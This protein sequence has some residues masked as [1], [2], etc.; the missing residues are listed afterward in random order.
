MEVVSTPDE[1]YSQPLSI[2]IPSPPD[3]STSHRQHVSPASNPLTVRNPTSADDDSSHELNDTHDT[4]LFSTSHSPSLSVLPPQII[5]IPKSLF[6]QA[7]KGIELSN[8]NEEVANN[9]FDLLQLAM[10]GMD[11]TPDNIVQIVGMG[12][13]V[14]EGLKRDNTPLS[15]NDKKSIVMIIV[16]RLVMT[17]DLSDT[18]KS[19]LNDIFVPLLL[20]GIIDSLC[21]LDVNDIASPA[22]KKT[23]FCCLSA[24]NEK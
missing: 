23:F 21:S 14:V 16:K 22:V 1:K 5:T 6:P 12:I 8:P 19:Y 18:V 11:L 9:A 7:S 15:N 13:K 2:I 17:T 10:K 3:L 4:H 24:S 20:P